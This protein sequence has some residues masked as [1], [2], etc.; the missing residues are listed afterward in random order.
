MAVPLVAFIEELGIDAI[1]LPHAYGEIAVGRL[2]EQMIM[3]VH[4]AVGVADPIVSLVD[5]LKGVE[6]IEAVPVIPEYGFFLIAAGSRVVDGA[7]V[8][9]AKGTYHAAMI[10]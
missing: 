4:E 9:D 2:D 3:V 5:A 8:F 6:E 10:A 1:Q 7:G